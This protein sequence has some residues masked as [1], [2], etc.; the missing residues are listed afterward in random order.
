ML[1]QITVSNFAI[2]E[3]LEI[4]FRPGLNI[5]SGETGA[6][7]SIIINAMNLVLG[8]R[9]SSDLIRSGCSEARVEALFTFPE[10]RALEDLLSD[11]GFSFDGDLLIKR[12]IFREGRNRVFIN[13]SMATLQAL[14]RLGSVL[15]SIS[16]QHEH[17]LLLEPERHLYILDDFGGLSNERAGLSEL[18]SGYQA[19][20]ED[21]RQIE[22]DIKRISEKQDLAGF[23]M[24]EIEEAGISPGEDEELVEEKRRLLHAEE[25]LEI[26]TEGYQI[27]YEQ[28]DSVL[29]SLSQ[30]IKRMKKGAE[31]DRR[32]S[33]IGEALF[34]IE[35]GLEDASLSLRDFQKMIHPDPDRLEEVVQRLDLLNRFKRKYGPTLEDILQFKDILTSK[36]FD[37]DEKRESLDQ[38]VTDRKE[39]ESAIIKRAG[40]LSEKRKKA[41]GKFEKAVEKELHNLNM[42]ETRFRVSFSGEDDENK[43]SD[44]DLLKDIGP[45]GLDRMEFIISANV[46]EELKPLS[47]IASGGELSRI[48]LAVKT[49]LA[50][51]ESVE[52][53]IFDEVDSGIS[54]A[55]AEVVGKK[56]DSLAGFH[57]MLC[58][59]HLPQIASQGKTHFQVSK[60]VTAG[61]TQAV[62]KELDYDSRVREI[63]RLLAGREITPKALAHAREMMG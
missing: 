45:H 51:T 39:L 9:A 19:L 8:G 58:I 30:C 31:L 7:K 25:L 40:V 60:V 17:Q 35:A 33:S 42:A 32:L 49:I 43:E 34:E 16:G 56:L 14:S 13:D 48:M 41:A 15:I 3:N 28:N 26:V 38:L 44:E 63:A 29:S 24:R 36:M 18:F 22:G 59:T 50:R 37:L 55:T 61:R 47:K 4:S 11:L 27:L 20:K 53:I 1:V 54:G 6:G 5:L 62:I 46:G 23:Q 12:T 2:I 10:N 52:T 21:I 57:Q